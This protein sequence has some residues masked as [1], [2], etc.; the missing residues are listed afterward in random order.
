MLNLPIRR[1]WELVCAISILRV[2]VFDETNVSGGAELEEVTKMDHDGYSTEV[3]MRS[4]V[5][6]LGDIVGFVAPT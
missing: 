2:D 5:C 4:L 6:G 3:V 1:L